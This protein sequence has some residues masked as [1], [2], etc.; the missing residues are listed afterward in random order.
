MLDT[1]TLPQIHPAALL[2][3]EMCDED[4]DALVEDIKVHGLRVPIVLHEGKVVDGRNRLQACV[5]ARVEPQFTDWDGQGSLIDF[6]W[7]MNG[8]RRHLTVSQRAAVAA[9]MKPLIQEEI[10]RQP[11]EDENVLAAEGGKKDLSSGRTWAGDAAQK[12]KVGTTA[13][14]D[15][16]RL[17]KESPELHEEVKAGKKTLSQAMREAG[18]AKKAEV[19]AGK[20]RVNGELVDDPP[21]V[22]KLRKDGLDPN[23]VVEVNDPGETTKVE[24]VAAEIEEAKAVKEEGQT[25]DEWIES[26]PA[27]A[28]LEPHAKTKFRD[29]ALFWRDYAKPCRDKLAQAVTPFFNK[30]R[31]RKKKAGAYM[32]AVRRF[33][34]V[35]GPERWMKCPPLDKG[36]CGGSGT[37]DI[38]ACPS[39]YGRGYLI[40]SDAGRAS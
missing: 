34:S 35:E 1:V 17:K 2:F 12:M 23:V 18:I 8:P 30:Y 9:D 11:S 37:T 40:S 24:D 4:F 15:A 22:A 39:C 10:T 5:F 29:D 21:E 36:G 13:V 33:L 7:S 16:A 28:A 27:Y 20:S 38:G 3:P 19:P 6:V 26:L 14:K 31:Q 25:D 32:Y